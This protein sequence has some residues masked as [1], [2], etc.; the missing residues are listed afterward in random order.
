MDEDSRDLARFLGGD[1]RAFEALVVRYEAR[2]RNLAYGM[3]RDRSLAEDVAQDTFLT[4]Y[5]KAKTFRG[6]G[7]FRGWLFRIAAHRAQ[8]E[9][10]RR[11][12]RGEVELDGANESGSGPGFEMGFALSKAFSKVR[13]EY[14]TVMILRE[15]EGLSYQEI[16]QALGWPLGTV[17]TRIHRARLE[18]RELLRESRPHPGE[19]ERNGA[20]SK[21]VQ[22][23]ARE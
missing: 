17:E 20:E 2:V 16:A 9:I 4:A 18:L 1:E 19:R 10:R 3:L 14:R 22:E 21:R 6:E 5:R 7:S 23:S 11:V 15:V 8:D 12:R 13:P